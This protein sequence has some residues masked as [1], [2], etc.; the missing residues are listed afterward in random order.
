MVSVCGRSLKWSLRGAQ[1]KLMRKLHE[2]LRQ[3]G[4]GKKKKRLLFPFFKRAEIMFLTS[5]LRVFSRYTLMTSRRDEQFCRL[6]PLTQMCRTE[7]IFDTSHLEHV[8][9]FI[10]IVS[11]D[12]V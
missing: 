5:E 1:R 2:Q 6:T 12:P 7:G 8:T 11:M 9:T 10:A 4:S 3:L